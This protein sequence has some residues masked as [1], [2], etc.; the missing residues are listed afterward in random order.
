MDMAAR[1]SVTVMH[2]RS[3]VALEVGHPLVDFVAITKTPWSC[4]M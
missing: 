1:K 4:G 3:V 2:G